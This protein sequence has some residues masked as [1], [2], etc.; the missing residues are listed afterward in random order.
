MPDILLIK[1]V[2]II[3]KYKDPAQEEY[4]AKGYVQTLGRIGRSR[5]RREVE[6]VKAFRA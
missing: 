1:V 4:S 2:L 6:R 3:N 5:Y